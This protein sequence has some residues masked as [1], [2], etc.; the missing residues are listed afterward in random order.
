MS[1]PRPA[2]A[3]ALGLPVL[4]G[5]LLAGSLPPWGF[6]PLALPGLVLLDRLIADRPAGSRFW[7]GWGVGLGLIG[8]T[9]FW[10]KD[11]TAPGYV[12]A[13]AF[14]SVGIGA[15]AALCPPGAGRHLALPAVWLLAEAFRGAWPFGGVPMS[16][17]AVGQ[18]GGPLGSIA[19]VGG[20]LLIGAVT[21]TAGVAV[22]AL[23]G[24]RAAALAAGALVAAGVAPRGSDT[25]RSLRV[26]FVQGGGPQGTRDDETDARVVFDRHLRASEELPTGLDLVVW[27]EDVVD[28]DRRV[29]RTELG[30]LLS[31]LA[32]RLDTTLVA[33]VVE[34]VGEK[35][36]TNAS[37]AW[38]PNGKVIDRYAKV[39][40]V[41]FGEYVPL[42]SLLEPLAGGALP[43]RDA[44]V[45]QGPPVLDVAGTRVGVLI[46]WEVFFGHRAR[47]AVRHGGR[48]IL[49][50]TNGSSYTGTLVQTQQ[51][52][53]SRLRAIETGRWLVQVAPTG[54][55]AFVSPG[56]KVIDR[57]AVSEAATAVQ[58]IT[59][60]KGQTFYTRLGD[61]PYVLAALVLLALA[62][63]RD[64]RGRRT[65]AAA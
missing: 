52:A 34:D 28:V 60:R 21:V 5:L 32:V 22:S 38:D 30:D 49:N 57:T 2:R 3:R 39:H 63:A 13:V 50:P 23:I 12:F 26:G 19:R 33:G 18:V 44:L 56:G 51:I 53:S 20:T 58:T 10:M 16:I 25:G 65:T 59:L 6:W 40:R 31:Q 11:L 29:D 24:R 48:A 62:W 64:R 7:R 14:F 45:G 37:V 27:P 35:H 46:S 15:A 17:L 8:P 1:S 61:R 36:F 9:M 43:D 4:A 55:S 41:P 54:F 47:A 42:R